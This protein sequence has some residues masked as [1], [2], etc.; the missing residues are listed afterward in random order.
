[1]SDVNPLEAQALKCDLVAEELEL[2]AKHMRTM[3]G[4]FRS[5]EVPR[6][7]AHSLAA[8]GHLETAKAVFVEIAVAH[9]GKAIP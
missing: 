8:Q 7:G 9:A 2:A 6:A 3:A 5:K 4:H 1:M